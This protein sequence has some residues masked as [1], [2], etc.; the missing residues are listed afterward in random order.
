MPQAWSKL[1]S[2]EHHVERRRHTALYRLN[3]AQLAGYLSAALPA[4][5]DVTE[6]LVLTMCGL[7]D[8]NSF[9]VT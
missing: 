5:C 1:M 8:T 4:D 9:E 3:A 7:L 2:L 6:E